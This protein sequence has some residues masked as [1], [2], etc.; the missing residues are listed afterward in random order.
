[1]RNN[2]KTKFIKMFKTK[3]DQKKKKN[4][5]INVYITD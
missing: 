5:Y 4:V 2:I 3:K 1:M